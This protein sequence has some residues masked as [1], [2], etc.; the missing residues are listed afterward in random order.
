VA[1]AGGVG[2]DLASKW[3]FAGGCRATGW[4]GV[5]R[6]SATA[7]VRP[8][9]GA[10]GAAP[11]PGAGPGGAGRDPGHGH[12]RA[13][14]AGIAVLTREAVL[15]LLVGM[16]A[17]RPAAALSPQVPVN[18]YAHRVWSA[19]QGLPQNTVRALVQSASGYVWVGTEEGLARFD[20]V[21]FVVF[22]RTS[23]PELRS[24]FILSLYEDRRGRL[25]V[26]TM[27]GGV[28]RWDGRQW[29]RLGAD[30][31]PRHD[32][33]YALVEGADGA[34]WIGTDDGLLRVREDPRGAWQIDAFTA[35]H[36]LASTRVRALH[37]DRRGVLWVGTVGG[38]LHVFD[39]RRFVA[40][41]LGAGRPGG[42]V[43]TIAAGS[44]SDSLLVGHAGGLDEFRDGRLVP[45]GGPGSP[46]GVCATVRDRDGNLWVGTRAGGLFRAAPGGGFRP[47][48]QLRARWVCSLLEERG[49][50]LLVGTLSGGLHQIAERAVRTVTREDGL[51]DDLVWSVSA[52]RDG[53]MWIGT[54]TGGLTRLH[55]G[56][57]RV[58]T[59]RDG[60]PSSMVR[61]V[62]QTAD[63][64]VW[65][66]T[67][68]GLARLH[69]GR[70]EPVPEL[71]DAHVLSLFEDGGGVL[72]VGTEGR[73]AWRLS[74]GRW[75]PVGPDTGP[76][77]N[78]VFAFADD[79]A[80]GV[81]MATIAGLYRFTGG[82]VVADTPRDAM[83][84]AM[85][86]D[87]GGSLWLATLG[88]GLLRKRGAQ[89]VAITKAHGLLKDTV[90]DLVEH[91]DRMWLATA[92]G[93]LMVD[94]R[95]LD[96]VADGRLRSV[97][98]RLLGRDDGMRDPECNGANQP[99]AWKDARGQLW[100]PT[101]HGVAVVDP[102]YR[103]PSPVPP[104]PHVEA[105]AIDGE[106]VALAGALRP[107]DVVAGTRRLAFTYTA[108]DFD[109]PSE[110]RFRYRLDGFDDDWV[111]A[112]GD[113]TVTY[114]NLPP[115]DYRFRVS[116]I[117]RDR[118]HSREAATL[119]LR[120]LPFFYETRWFYLA[121]VLLII[122]I[123]G[124][125]YA[126]RVSRLKQSELRL[127]R[128]V[129]ERTRSLREAQAEL[130]RAERMASVAT[131][132]RGIAHELNNPIGFIAGNVEPLRRYCQFLSRVAGELR[133]G[134]PR[135]AGEVAA[136]TRLSPKKDLAY[137]E[138]D[139]ERLTRDI[140]EGARRARLIISDLQRFGV[141][142]QRPLEWIA[143]S[144]LVEQTVALLAPRLDG[145]EL[146]TEVAADI[147]PVLA[148]A[149]HLEQ[150]LTNLLDNAI[151]A[152]PTVATAGR[153]RGTIS[154]S[155]ARLDDATVELQV[156]DS[157][158][159]MPEAVRMRACE[160]FFTTRPDG[161]GS[162][163]GLAIVSATVRE[164]RGR[165]EIRSAP[166][167]G[168]EVRVV[169]P[170]QAL[171][172]DP[173]SDAASRAHPAPW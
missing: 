45:Q 97:H 128:L 44:R 69:H 35:A 96:R 28:H 50:T 52:G 12:R 42:D 98:G 6:G 4:A 113:R 15:A 39:G 167:Q 22:D 134:R 26:G 130:V 9:R 100:F 67:S 73:G 76:P 66:G 20:G 164:H 25:W 32:N 63:G 161:E 138:R 38:G 5:D 158:A 112:G 155:A 143:V 156:C 11:V 101:I 70:F 72:W 94:K 19:E 57:A 91:D 125:I 152:L 162:G 3:A 109:A 106:P 87:P 13:R 8:A 116:A 170:V 41:G 23:T 103:P 51:G 140:A 24:Q 90:V 124:A 135:S 71:G 79:G 150:L 133:D 7:V 59:P 64:T 165:L 126:V 146:R 54:F 56:T 148:R 119:E 105:A 120:V 149:G 61:A 95:E 55:R 36:G 21:R 139:L 117:T 84:I 104:L 99:A 82:R 153:R 53:A 46:E 68:K 157:G 1:P 89:V 129:D 169:L 77:S 74:Q 85:H 154:I 110:L 171:E 137:V 168:T 10:G 107:L 78:G 83:I 81:W 111:D 173:A 163:L 151:R 86:R 48:T 27:A 88:Q 58:Y 114:T 147:P 142:E 121:T 80:G 49:G 16:L 127:A 92:R 37:V 136:L 160:P 172:P 166:G 30:S 31:R 34:M 115:G 159:G 102:G 47:A 65:A 131:V 29:R 108:I 144:R 132:M 40:H 60:L 33:V 141:G 43:F 122:A 62:R 2:G 123:L 75:C 18:H 14:S 17:V 118:V 145:V 93:I